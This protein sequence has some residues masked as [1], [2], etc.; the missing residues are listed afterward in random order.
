MW[1]GYRCTDANGDT[2]AIKLL[3]NM[4]DLPRFTREVN[5]TSTVSSRRGGSSHI[6][7]A[8][9]HDIHEGKW[10]YLVL[11]YCDGGSLADLMNRRKSFSVESAWI[12]I[13][14]IRGL[15]IAILSSGY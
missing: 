15:K 11:E 7:S 13:Q 10:P 6:V 8:Y 4:Y 9:A 3:H 1:F 14:A 12:L 2:V 5:V